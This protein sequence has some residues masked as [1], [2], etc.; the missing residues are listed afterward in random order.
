MKTLFILVAILHCS[1]LHAE[2]KPLPKECLTECTTPFGQELGHTTNKVIAYSNC[3]AH[4]VYPSPVEKDGIFLGIKWQCVEFARRW[5]FTEFGMSFPS[6]DFA[7]EFWGK[8]DHLVAV[9]EKKDV[10]LEKHLN[11][12]LAIPERGDILLYGQD[13]AGTGH[14]AIILRVDRRKK[15]I[16][17]GEENLE[18][19][20]WPSDYARKVSYVEVKGKNWILDPYLIGWKSFKKPR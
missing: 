19:K 12:D 14:I 17:I 8:I 16:Y 11:G 15:E 1:I 5:L 10:P 13:L 18:N 2:E 9:A 6:I 4:C 3:Q 7:Y 20:A